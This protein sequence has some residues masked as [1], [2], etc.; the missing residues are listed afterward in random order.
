MSAVGG[1]IREVSLDGRIYQCT[2]EAGA[3]L[4]PGIYSNEVKISGGG[5]PYL[6][7]KVEPSDVDGIV[8]LIDNVQESMKH[9]DTLAA[10]GDFWPAT[11]TLADGRTYQGG[12]MQFGDKPAYNTAEGTATIKLQGA[13]M[14]LQ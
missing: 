6:L 2:S 14:E 1:P 8:I 13:P 12:Q 11:I 9:L 7:K 3:T 10:R 5:Q 4:K